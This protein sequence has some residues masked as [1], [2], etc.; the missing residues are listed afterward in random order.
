MDTQT[1]TTAAQIET[2]RAEAAA[3][4]DEAQVDVCTAALEGDADARR[5]CARVIAEADAQAA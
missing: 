4:G 5:E 1:V 2:L 3:A